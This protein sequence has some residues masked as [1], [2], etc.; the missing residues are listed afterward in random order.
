MKKENRNETKEQ[1]DKKRKESDKD[2]DV[3][4]YEPQDDK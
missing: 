1:S 4:I 3:L 2:T